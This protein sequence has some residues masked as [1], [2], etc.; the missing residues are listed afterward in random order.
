MPETATLCE[1]DLAIDAEL[2]E[3]C[4]S[5][6][7]I[8]GVTPTNA[9][10][11]RDE[12]VAGRVSDPVFEYRDLGFDPCELKERLDGIA[13]SHV[14]DTTLG[15]LLRAK[16]REA[17]L[18]MPLS[19]ELY[20]GISPE[21]RS[22]AEDILS[23]VR[24]PHPREGVLGASDFLRMAEAELD[25]YRS[26]APDIEVSAE[27]HDDVIGVMV[28]GPRLLI[29][30]DLMVTPLRAE[31]LLQHEVGTHLV[32]QINGSA[33]PIT[34]L[35]SGLAG[36]DETQEGLAV[37]AE[38]ACGGLTTGRLR[39]LAARVVTAHRR[40][41]GA[42]FV[43]AYRGLV[44]TGFSRRLSFTTTM[45]VYRSGGLIKD[46]IYLRGLIDV[47]AHLADGGLLDLLLRGKF[48]LE[49]LPL[50]MD[51]EERGILR[52]ALVTP[53]FLLDEACVRRLEAAA[54]ATDLITLTE[55]T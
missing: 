27:I 36:Y 19:I 6:Q 31:A 30:A 34:S 53:R 48:A 50:V 55:G 54:G 21:L 17:G 51:L 26:V 10:D 46:A 11:Y 37:L 24:D 52:P 45:R 23:H 16:Q 5:F 41:A 1:G 20:R 7:F 14:E 40:V 33:Q 32:T 39:Q 22:R 44:D 4:E 13:V 9:D 25:H 29:S 35:G 47:L 42:S 38:V 12:F 18:L 3:L 8:L 2:T 49:D 15:N 43:D 28:S